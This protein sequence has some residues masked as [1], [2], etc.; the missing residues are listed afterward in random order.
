[1]RISKAFLE[2]DPTPMAAASLAQVHRARL[3][4]WREV[5]VK[6]QRP[7]VRRQIAE[8]MEVLEEIVSFLD[9]HTHFGQR[10]QLRKIFEE[11]RRTLIQELDY[12]REATNLINLRANLREFQRIRI[13]EPIDDYTTRTVLTMDY[14]GGTKITELSRVVRTEIDGTALA[15]DLFR[16][17]LKQVLVDGLFHA[18][19]H[20]GNILLTDD[21]RIALLDLA[22]GRDW[23]RSGSVL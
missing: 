12:Q 18:D 23:P 9:Q 11:F 3:R 8:D 2:F 5:V 16:A 6:V 10:Y 13:P 17:Y 19:P 1:V 20:P 21:G 15:D 14:V 4:N 7:E 22:V